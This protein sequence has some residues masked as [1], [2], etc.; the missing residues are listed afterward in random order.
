MAYQ[1]PNDTYFEGQVLTA[2]PQRLRLMLLDGALQYAR[3][4]SQHWQAGRLYEGGEAVIGCQ[5]IVTELLRGLRPE[6]APELVGNVAAV[7]NFVFRALIE[8]GLK[9]DPAKLDEAISVLEIERETWRQV[10]EQLGS[11]LQAAPAPHTKAM[12]VTS[13]T[14]APT[15]GFSVDA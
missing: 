10:C 11:S 15:G 14:S 3:R 1:R 8:A 13:A 2:T 5:R 12:H 6:M 4:A 7:Y 9:R